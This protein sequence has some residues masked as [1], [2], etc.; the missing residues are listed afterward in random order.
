MASFRDVMASMGLVSTG[1]LGFEASGVVIQSGSKAT[2]FKPGDRVSVVG[3][4]TH[5]TSIRVDSRLVAPIP[6]G[7]S[8]EEA[9]ALPIV[10]TTAYHTLVNLARLRKGQSV[11]IHAAA[12]GVGQ[13]A[14][15]LATHLSL[16]VYATVGT[17]DKRQLLVEKY[18]IPEEHIFNSRDISFVKGIKRATDGRGVDCVLNSLSGELLRASWGCLATFGTFIELGLRDIT[19]N[20]RLDMR[21]FSKVTT[22]TFCNILAV[23]QEDPDFMGE[24]LKQTFQLI[25]QKVLSAPSPTTVYPVGQL[26]KAFRTMQQGKHRGKLVLSFS[27]DAQAPVLCEAKESL[28]LDPDATY[29]IVGGLGGLGRSMACEFVASGARNLAFVSRSGDATP[30]AKAVMHELAARNVRVRA[31][32][33]DVADESSFLEAMNQCSRDL[34]PIKGV[35]Q[36]AMVLRDVVFEKMS[37]EQWTLPMRP[38]VQGTWN[39]H[40]Y[41]DHSRPLDFMVICSSTSGI[42]GY[43]SQAQ[44]AAGNTYQNALAYYRRKRG[45]KAV[46]VNLTIIREIGILAEQGTT[47]NIA[48]WEEAL[49]IKEP[50]FHALMKSLINGQRG[51]VESLPMPPQISTGLGTADIMAA[52][53]LALPDYFSNPMF[54]P[55]A[56]SA[57]SSGAIADGRTAAV[58]LASRLVE[59]GGIEEATETIA[60]ALVTKVAD[61]LQMPSSEVDPSRAMYRYGVDSLVA[62]EVRNWITREMK[63]S[64]ALLEILAAVPMNDFARTIAER[65]K[66]LSVS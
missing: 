40:K 57:V 8:F 9:A 18:K 25:D 48:I 16:V 34:P 64:I 14:I 51:P 7:M 28:R 12:G 56:V 13:A 26:H 59:A 63:A 23:M 43:P 32:R 54:G 22:F 38:K 46:S 45:L 36:M 20:T 39:I 49:G 33:A 53:G 35:I 41:F 29:L 10:G 52:H 61:I 17:E 42:H 65:S 60:D 24:I 4:H 15:Q 44:Y 6:D 62:L 21:P 31:Y 47:G 19:N 2:Q 11:L 3:E 30:A 1:I 5:G 27:E 66:Y 58:S 55:L 50:A 37:Y